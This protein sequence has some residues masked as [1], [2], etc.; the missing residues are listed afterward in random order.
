MKH[1]LLLALGAFALTS[2]QREISS[3]V[4][5]SRQVGEVAITY[6]GVIR[7][8]RQVTVAGERT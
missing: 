4:Y 5:A 1:I 3:D 8:V 6:P 7:S 2:C